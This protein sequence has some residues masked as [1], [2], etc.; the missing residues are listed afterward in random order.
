[1]GVGLVYGILGVAR[2]LVEASTG[3][4]IPLRPPGTL[5]WIYVGAVVLAGMI[6]GLV[7]AV[8]AYRTALHDGLAV[9]V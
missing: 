3:L 2:P 1:M 9:R 8:K 5:E 4:F 6:L 7:P